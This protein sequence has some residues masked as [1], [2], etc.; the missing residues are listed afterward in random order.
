MLILLVASSAMAMYFPFG[1]SDIQFN[2]E[3]NLKSDMK[4]QFERSALVK[5]HFLR[6][7]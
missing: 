2:R 4:L 1:E 3:G 6:F 5:L 7:A